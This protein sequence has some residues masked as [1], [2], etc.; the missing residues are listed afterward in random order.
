MAKGGSIMI[1]LIKKISLVLIAAG[2]L[3][4]LGGFAAVDFDVFQLSTTSSE[5]TTMKTT[6]IDMDEIN[7]L[8]VTVS[9]GDL[10]I[11]PVK[12][13][14]FIITYPEG[15]LLQYDLSVTKHKIELKKEFKFKL[16]S[17]FEF[18]DQSANVTIQVPEAYVGSM[19]ITCHHGDME[20][21]DL[22]VSQFNVDFKY[23]DIQIDNIR[24]EQAELSFAHGTSRID[25]MSADSLII[26]DGYMES[27]YDNLK[28]NKAI[29]LS[30]KHGSM[31]M[32]NTTAKML[33]A[34]LRYSSMQLEDSTFTDSNK[35]S[36]EHEKITV[37]NSSMDNLSINGSYG[38][39]KLMDNK[40]KLITV[41]VKHGDIYSSL[42]GK[43]NDYAIDVSINRGKSDLANQKPEGYKY[44]LYITLEY[45]NA[46][47]N[48]TK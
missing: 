22:K 7:K 10:K 41:D 47:I 26:N 2:L 29:N 17:W 23:G 42:Q 36:Y 39:L 5:D 9:E 34:D 31:K 25:V 48:F 38:D 44:E 37:M 14:K 3:L 8:I 1:Q 43:K 32:M 46:D 28:I 30:S 16:M 11:T 13:D 27:E 45:G 24:A 19:D 20:I 4:I 33:N 15:E 18:P 40:V 6:E 21:N 12:S 35:I